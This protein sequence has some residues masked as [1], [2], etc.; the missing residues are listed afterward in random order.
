M[1]AN[2]AVFQ[3][4]LKQQLEP[5]IQDQI[6]WIDVLLEDTLNTDWQNKVGIEVDMKNNLFE[7]TSLTGWMTAYS[8]TEGGALV[9]SDIGLE[10]MQVAPKFVTASYRLWH[11]AIVATTK[12]EASLKQWVELY[13]L[14]I[15]RAMMRAKGRILRWDGTGIIWLLPN[16]WAQTGTAIT[17]IG[18]A[19]GTIVSQARYGLGT[20]YFQKGQEISFGTEADFAGGT[21]VDAII[22]SVDSDTQITL[23][24]SKTVGTTATGN[25]RAWTNADTW[26]IRLKG[27][28]GATPMGLL[29]LVDDGNLSPLSLDSGKIQNVTRSTTPYMKSYVADKANHSTIIKDHRDMY[30]AVVRY[31]PN[32]KY[33]LLSED[34]YADY[35]DAITITV[36]ANMSSTPYTSKLGVGHAG[37]MFA[38]GWKPVPMIMDTLL[39]YGQSMLL[40]TDQLFCADLFK[41]DYI[42]DGIMTRVTGSKLYETVRCAYYNN[43]T[44]SSRKLGWRIN[45]QS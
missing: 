44:Y 40:D 28:Y 41:D 6:D 25:N 27:T 42:E 5:K 2:I 15:R 36:Q 39:P 31:N 21:Q 13:W 7:I 37:L 29:G 4:M 16:T 1:S 10:K 20:Q 30:S 19:K 18:K 8:W 14:E 38:Y 32:V 35:T 43:W 24:A 23:T 12:T 33:F 11:E 45:Y 3:A 26:H 34:V 22:A 9:A 17:I